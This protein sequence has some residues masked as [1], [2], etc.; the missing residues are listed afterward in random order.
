MRTHRQAVGLN[1]ED[2]GKREGVRKI[3]QKAELQVHRH[4]P[5]GVALQ[6]IVM[7]AQPSL[8][9]TSTLPVFPNPNR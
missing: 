7:G 4:L 5:L 8:T 1:F 6:L 2:A 9:A 3:A